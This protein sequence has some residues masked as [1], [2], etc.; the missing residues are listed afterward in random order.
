MTSQSPPLV[1]ILTPVYNGQQY[2]AECI[3]S[4]LAQTYTNWEYVIVNNC[5]TDRTLSIAMGY[6]ATEPRI[7][8]HNNPKFLGL[9]ENH[10]NALNQMSPES[11]YCKMLHADDLL[12]PECVERMVA[13]AQD[14]PSLGVV[15]A[16]YIGGDF[17]ANT[18]PYPQGV[19]SGQALGRLCLLSEKAENILGG[20]TAT[21]IRAD[22][23]RSRAVF[24]NERNLGADREAMYDVLRTCD[25]GFVHQILTYY[26]YH[27]ERSTRILPERLTLY[28]SKVIV[29]KKYGRNYLNANEVRVGLKKAL[30]DY[31]HMM[32][33]NVITL[34]DRDVRKSNLKKLEEV[35][36][37][38][39][40]TSLGGAVFAILLDALLNPKRT[41]E[42]IIGRMARRRNAPTPSPERTGTRPGAVGI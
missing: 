20:P 34:T 37:P 39:S 24:Y 21:L 35:G 26:R 13:M 7:R 29:L 5:S 8:I 15:G 25:F 22:L 31:Y 9:I 19:I 3:E 11:A 17:L 36:Y 16:Y 32:A 14:H 30:S 38:F 12:L 27:A 6:A 1:S 41:A 23:I 40:V 18:I 2:L 42:Q 4:V 33:R 28:L 10:N